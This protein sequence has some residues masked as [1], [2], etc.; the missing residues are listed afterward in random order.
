[1][2][3][4]QKTVPVH[5]SPKNVNSFANLMDASDKTIEAEESKNLRRLTEN[6]KIIKDPVI[7]VIAERQEE[8]DDISESEE[9]SSSTSKEGSFKGY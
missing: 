2:Q 3:M 4:V 8:E 9:F 7:K 5:S 1:M 6:I